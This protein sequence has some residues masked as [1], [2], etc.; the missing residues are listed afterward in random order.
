I[1]QAKFPVEIVND[2]KSAILL[3][4]QKISSL[5]KDQYKENNIDNNKTIKETD[6][7]C[8]VSGLPI[9]SK[10]EWTNIDLGKGLTDQIKRFARD[11]W[12]LELDGYAVNFELLENDIIYNCAQG[13]LKKDYVDPFFKLYE[14]VLDEAGLISKGYYY[15]IL[16]WEKMENSEWAAK[17][18][19]IKRLKKINKKIPCRFSSGFGLNSIMKSIINT[20]GVFVP[21]NF[22]I[23]N[24]FKEAFSTIEKEK[25]K[26]I[27]IASSDKKESEP[28]SL[29]I[30]KNLKNQIDNLLAFMGEVNWDTTGIEVK[31]DENMIS[32]DF[33]PLYDS[34]SLIKQDFDS[35]FHEKDNAEEKLKKRN[36]RYRTILENI[37]DGYYEVDIKGNLTFFN[38]ALCAI[39]GYPRKELMGMN[40]KQYTDK[41]NS[42]KIFQFFNNLYKGGTSEHAFDWEFIKKNGSKIFVETSVTLMKDNK[43]RAIG[44]RGIVRD[45]TERVRSE[46]EST[47]INEELAS[48][49]DELEMS[50]ERAN[51]MTAESAMAYLELDQIFQ[52]STEGMWVISSSF[53]IVRVNKMFLSM[54]DKSNEEIM[55]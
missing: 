12:S 33:L 48:L 38:D 23:A 9:T 19:Y 53:D 47:E 27:N 16:N 5:S 41:E 10:S 26:T 39:Y 11:D 43:D 55:G 13:I 17:A 52:A 21:F 4:T 34:I 25:Y 29:K 8:T 42:K 15:R 51:Q 7:Y 49:N 22:T 46:K 32:D 35:A 24:N 6:N 50:I 20:S 3:A 36:K 40:Y 54:I 37:N 1:G 30:D 2:Y 31:K 28:E 45:R 44:F 14:K 18:L